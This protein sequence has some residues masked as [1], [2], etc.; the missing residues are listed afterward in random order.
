MAVSEAVPAAPARR[1]SR[2]LRFGAVITT[3]LL[4]LFGVPWWTLV[5][6][7]G[8]STGLTVAGTLLF[9]GVALAFPV[10]MFTG[11]GRA[12]GLGCPDRRHHP[13]RDLGAVHLVAAGQPAADTAGARRGRRPDPVTH[14]GR[15][16]RG[17][18][19]R[20]GRLGLRRGDAGTP[21]APGGRA[22]GP[23]RRGPGRHQGGAAHR[24]PLRADRPGAVVPPGHRRGQ[25]ARRR[26]SSA[27]PATS[28]TARWPSAAN[29]PRR[30]ATYAPASPAPM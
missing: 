21:G 11:H 17:D 4:L 27:T 3:A 29:R 8:A 10:L 13:G 5:A 6:A 18:L 12:P 23:A 26:T 24:H 9:V 15:G 1:A 20:P 14:R 16:R 25:R 7:V 19:R 30:W 28:P 22:A 2:A